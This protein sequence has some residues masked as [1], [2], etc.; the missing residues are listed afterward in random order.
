MKVRTNSKLSQ[1]TS[2]MAQPY[3]KLKNITKVKSN[4]FKRLQKIISMYQYEH[5]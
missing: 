3:T 1:R 2:F 5:L 4:L